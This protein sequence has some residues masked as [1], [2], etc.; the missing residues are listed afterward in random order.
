MK[1]TLLGRAGI[2]ALTIGAAS[3]GSVVREGSGTSFLI[4]SS[5][6]GASGAEPEEFGNT[7]HSDVETG[8]GV[9]NDFGQVVFA[10]GLK[11]PGSATSANEPTQNQFITIDRYRVRYIRADG[12][13]TQGVDVPYGFDG[14][15]T[16]TVD[17][18]G[19]AGGFQLV[20]HL[21]KVE[22]PLGSLVTNRVIISTIAEI[23]FFGRDLT[24][25][26]VTAVGRMSID[27]GN[28]AD[29]E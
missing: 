17:G 6:E 13:N 12:R 27:F 9:F 14:A 11:D 5:L 4:I 28:F 1:P 22:A 25:R 26:E 20:R 18:D 3:C 15:I 7:L 10:L 2:L 29:P 21:A 24:G 8:G 23:T 19:G 16:I